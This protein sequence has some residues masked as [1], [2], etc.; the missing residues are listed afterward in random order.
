MDELDP[1]FRPADEADV[2]AMVALFQAA[3]SRWPAVD[4][5]VPVADHLRWKMDCHPR[6]AGTHTTMEIDGEIVGAVLQFCRDV[7]VRDRILFAHTGA[8]MAIHPRLQGRGLVQQAQPYGKARVLTQF[9]FSFGTQN[10]HPR[11][12]GRA[13]RRGEQLPVANELRM[14]V[15]TFDLRSFVG[16]HGRRGGWRQLASTAA[17]SAFRRLRGRS[18]GGQANT[19]LSTALAFDDR[20]DRLWD[21]A[22]PEFD[23]IPD[24][25]ATYLDWRYSDRRGGESLVRIASEADEIWGYSVLRWSGETAQLADLLVDPAHPATL[26]AL[27][28]DAVDRAAERGASQIT[29]AL[30]LEHPYRQ[31][32]LENGFLAAGGEMRLQYRPHGEHQGPLAFLGQDVDARIHI[33][34]GDLDYI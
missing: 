30:P 34:L 25:R 5:D 32:L 11:L 23:F 12:Q 4:V 14:L 7:K 13:A 1:T 22:S 27:V 8:D 24:R 21:S 28:A 20:F 9:D 18:N 19:R 33:T 2:D 29:C 17:T 26:D 15:R 6:A 3:F 31:T 10:N 16:V